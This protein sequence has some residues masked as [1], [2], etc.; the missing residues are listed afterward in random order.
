MAIFGDDYVK[1]AND[2]QNFF[3]KFL[4]KLFQLD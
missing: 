3:N 4:V 1:F 2:K